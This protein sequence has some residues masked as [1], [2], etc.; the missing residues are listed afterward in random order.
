MSALPNIT[1]ATEGRIAVSSWRSSI[2]PS[3]RASPEVQ[4]VIA[5]RLG[6]SKLECVASTR[7]ALKYALAGSSAV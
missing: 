6:R 7:V 4:P 1:I 3:S 5:A 2:A